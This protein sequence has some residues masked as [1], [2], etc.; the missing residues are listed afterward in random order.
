M[1]RYRM[2]DVAM[3]LW[4][5]LVDNFTFHSFPFE[6][7][8]LAADNAFDGLG[9]WLLCTFAICSLDGISSLSSVNLGS[10]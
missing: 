1:S 6:T 4:P 9:K 10:R 3:S 2:A 8:G 5:W 7:Q